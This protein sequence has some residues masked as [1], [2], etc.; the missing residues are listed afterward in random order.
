MQLYKL[1]RD[2]RW[3]ISDPSASGVV[4]F[5][6]LLDEGFRFG[7]PLAALSLR[8]KSLENDGLCQCLQTIKESPIVSV[9]YLHEVGISTGTSPRYL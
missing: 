6:R 5:D 1:I 4:G 3:T 2:R 7:G 8:V 9:L